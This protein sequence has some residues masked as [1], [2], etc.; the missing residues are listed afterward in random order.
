M[1]FYQKKLDYKKQNI[2]WQN[3][4]KPRNFQDHLR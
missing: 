1:R 2:I 3:L 4:I